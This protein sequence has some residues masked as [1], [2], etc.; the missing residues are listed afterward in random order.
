MLI[1]FRYGFLILR[2]L[3]G[4]AGA[5]SELSPPLPPPPK[6]KYTDTHCYKSN[7]FRLV[8]IYGALQR[9]KLTS[10]S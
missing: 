10:A 9:L 6:D 1:N 8:S 3:G 7:P 5:M 2:G 4:I